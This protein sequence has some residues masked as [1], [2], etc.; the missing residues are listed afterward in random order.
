MNLDRPPAPNPYEL[1][2]AVPSFNLQS[3][4]V[5]TGEQFAA[6]H[7]N[8]GMGQSGE[9]ASPAL[10]WSGFPTGTRS[11]ALTMFDA[12]APTAS[13]FWHWAV[14]DIP[15]SVTEL[16]RGSG[17]RGGQRLPAG[18]IQLANDTGQDRYD[19]PAPPPGDRAHHYYIAVHAVD[20]DTLGIPPDAR[21]AIAGFNLTFHVL[22]R[23]VIVPVYRA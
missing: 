15:A 22:A 6:I 14:V 8:D 3:S 11:F 19:G 23:A 16:A 5:R 12:D 20:V 18:A 21:C 7:V 2:P 4:D 13:G 17:A 9:N 1:L 10:R